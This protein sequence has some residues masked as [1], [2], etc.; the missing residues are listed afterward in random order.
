MSKPKT[1]CRLKASH[2]DG[3]RQRQKPLGFGHLEKRKVEAD[4]SGGAITSDA[5]LLLVSQVDKRYR[6]TQR[7]AQCF[8]DYRDS[9]RVEHSVEQMI[10][11]RTYG[12][13][14]GYED[15]ND[16]EQLRH[17][18]MF[19]VAVGQ[20]E[21]NHARC[22]PLAGKS[23]LNRLELGP[24]RANA[25][26]GKD[27][28]VKVVGALKAMQQV[29]VDVF[30]ELTPKPLRWLVL[31]FDVTD[32]PTHGEQELSAFNGYYDCD[33]YAPLYVFCGHHLLAARLR[34]SNVDPAEGALDELQRLVPL[35]RQRWPHV[36]ILLRGDS[37]YS[38]D[39]IMSWCE[40][41]NVDYVLGQA[42]NQRLR[43]MTQR[44]ER[45]A[46]QLYEVSQIVDPSEPPP[47]LYRTVYYR[48]LKS[49]SR[50]RRLVCQM[51]YD[52]K[53]PHCRFVVTSLPTS[54]VCPSQLYR[55]WYCPRGD[56]ENRIKE[57]QLDLFSDRTS[58]HGFESNQLRL[59]FSSLAYVLLQ[60]MRQSVLAKTDLAKAQVSTIRTRLLKL[61]AQVRIS[62]RRIHIAICSHSPMQSLFGLVHQRLQ[63]ET[64]TG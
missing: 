17:D 52:E 60:A 13:V 28:Y 32:D 8:K 11:Q 45:R 36:K 3:S 42:S 9:K 21:S 7:F 16:H 40:G 20:L 29:F 25:K 55:D 56:M 57:N 38:R 47:P 33:C 26:E 4:F 6:I 41:N 19:G 49:W 23:T 51:T 5:G 64:N 30:F 35:I 39:D 12:L 24:S 31:D 14:Q 37:A 59:Y 10:A 1:Q 46:Q 62:V 50:Q 22:A 54:Q 53:G 63:L 15:V 18:P 43:R 27:R 48:T 2:R 58:S 34:A 61:G 44:L